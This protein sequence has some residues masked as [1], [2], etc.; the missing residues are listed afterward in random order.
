MLSDSSFDHDSPSSPGMSATFR[1]R[2]SAQIIA[3]SR[4]RMAHAASAHASSSRP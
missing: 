4:N 1:S 3:I 2:T